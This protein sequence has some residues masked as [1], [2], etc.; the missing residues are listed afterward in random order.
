MKKVQ[1]KSNLEWAMYCVGRGWQV[2][3]VHSVL[4]GRC[5]CG[6]AECGN[7]GKHPRTP[8]GFKDA[9]TDAQQIESWWSKWPEANI[10]VLTG[11]ESGLIVL[12]IDPRH[13]GFTSLNDLI[14]K[15]GAL[16]KTY[17]VETGGG[18]EHY[19]FKSPE[20]GLKCRSSVLDGIDVKAD[21]GYVVGAGSSH[22]TGGSYVVAEDAE[23]VEA[24]EWLVELTK[25][26]K[27]AF[28]IPTNSG[29]QG[30]KNIPLGERNSTLTSLAGS[31]HHNGMS[32][33]SIRKALLSDNEIR[34]Q[35]PLDDEEVNRI[36]NSVI[37]YD[38]STGLKPIIN[39]RIQLTR[40]GSMLSE[41]EKEMEYVVDDLLP[42]SGLSLLCGK[43]KTG[44]TT[45]VRQLALCVAQGT[46]FL[47][48]SVS[49]GAVLYFALEEK[50]SEITKHFRAMGVV[51]DDDIYIHVS[52]ARYDAFKEVKKV[53]DEYRPSLVVIDPLFRFV[54]VKD[55]NDYNSMTKALDPLIQLARETNS[56]I[57]C[58]HHQSKGD[59]QGTDGIL[60]STAIFGTVDTALML[61]KDNH[62]GRIISS[63]QRYGKDLEESV[64]T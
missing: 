31:M 45:L 6:N 27:S 47:D 8:K 62:G 4:D 28:V 18:G 11:L 13:E 35:E 36:V 51:G 25:T 42:C 34:C 59:R 58:V 60:G 24:P 39:T 22:Y 61:K 64:L 48:R 52:G 26:K 37:K 14:K 55:G 54:N 7:K 30:N 2:F 56:H 19:Y 29:E 41:P 21:G 15:H 50:R 23:I 5:S 17:K 10:G 16:P 38:N 63:T 33:E 40:I 46:D 32:E 12:D 53:I 57:I 43:P 1:F 44:K 3:P 49:K 9:T 20:G